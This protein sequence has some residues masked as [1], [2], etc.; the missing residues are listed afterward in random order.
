MKK[1]Y[2]CLA[3][4]GFG[5]SLRGQEI[6]SDLIPGDGYSQPYGFD[7]FQYHFPSDPNV[8]VD[9]GVMNL[10]S[11]TQYVHDTITVSRVQ[12]TVFVRHGYEFTGFDFIDKYLISNDSIILLSKGSYFE[13]GDLLQLEEIYSPNVTA[14]SFPMFPGDEIISS[15]NQILYFYGDGTSTSTEFPYTI[16]RTFIGRMDIVSDFDSYLDLVFIREDLIDNE[17]GEIL[18]TWFYWFN[19]ND[20]FFPIFLC[21]PFLGTEEGTNLLIIEHLPSSGTFD[22]PDDG[23]ERRESL[24]VYPNPT[25]D[26]VQVLIQEGGES[27]IYSMSGILVKSFGNQ[28]PG[29]KTFDISDLA[30]GMY[31]LQVGTESSKLVVH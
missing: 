24:S 22:I 23:R 9:G 29:I 15:C 3:V 16:K 10:G 25:E 7:E 1:L 14:Y 20:L 4:V 13:E 31:I 21:N 18:D 30:S 5:L 2:V 26:R 19:Q 11:S 12:D 28:Q 8:F 6:T 27:V 17:T